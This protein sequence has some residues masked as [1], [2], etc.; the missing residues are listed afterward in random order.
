MRMNASPEF[1]VALKKLRL[2]TVNS[3]MLFASTIWNGRIVMFYYNKKTKSIDNV[4]NG[5]LAQNDMDSLGKVVENKLLSL[6]K[7]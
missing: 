1:H 4:F 2:A 7:E 3:N 6:D 5:E